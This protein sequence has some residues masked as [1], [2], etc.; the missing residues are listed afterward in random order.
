MKRSYVNCINKAV[1]FSHYLKYLLLRYVIDII[2]Y[3]YCII[4]VLYRCLLYRHIV[5]CYHCIIV[6][7]HCIIVVYYRDTHM[8]NI[9][10]T[11]FSKNYIRLWLVWLSWLGVILPS[12][13]LPVQFSV[14]AHAWVAGSVLA[15]CAGE[16]QPI[17]VSLSHRCFSP[18]ISPYL[19]LSLDK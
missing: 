13:R 5:V 1:I 18:S 4:Y 7:L 14:R 16:R 9:K 2:V 6:M 11:E 15:Q 17:N 19:P 8:I 3:Y 10:G 12:K